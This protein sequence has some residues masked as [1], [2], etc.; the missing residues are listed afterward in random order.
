MTKS[1]VKD[2]QDF[3][4]RAAEVRGSWTISERRRRTGL[5]PDAP[6]KLREFIAGCHRSWAR[7]AVVV[8][9]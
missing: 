3:R 8:D 1:N 9:R 6:A 2:L 7:I 5:P 4:Q